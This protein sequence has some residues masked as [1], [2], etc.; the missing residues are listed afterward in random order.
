MLC[1]PV[2]MLFQLCTLPL[3]A[4]SVIRLNFS[5]RQCDSLT[6][7]DDTTLCYSHFITKCKK[8]RKVDGGC[9]VQFLSRGK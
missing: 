1:S 4:I 9:S 3:G 2:F 5:A 8:K 7:R 6:C